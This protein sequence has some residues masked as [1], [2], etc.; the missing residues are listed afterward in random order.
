[1]LR[2][3]PSE[4]MFSQ[5]T[6]NNVFDRKSR[7]RNTLVGETL[8]DICEG[9]CLMDNL[10]SI[11]VMKRDGKWVTSDNRRLWVFRELERL[12]KCDSIT[13]NETSYIDARKLNSS[14]GGVSVGFHRGRS[15]GGRW[16]NS[17]TVVSVII[18]ERDPVS[19]SL[20]TTDSCDSGVNIGSVNSAKEPKVSNSGD[21]SKIEETE[22]H[23]DKTVHT[24]NENISH[25][26]ETKSNADDMNDFTN[27]HRLIQSDLLLDSAKT[28]RSPFLTEWSRITKSSVE[29]G[30]RNI[31]ES[32]FLAEW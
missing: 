12:G 13:V 17:P 19:D 6:I 27:P 23:T 9:R 30:R 18:K 8:D 3:K 7:H 15:P 28:L 29:S 4:I 25:Q 26:T 22:V 10:P 1:M 14:N 11:S 2:L 16:H 32:F 20:L 5:A 24:E 21:K 31:Q